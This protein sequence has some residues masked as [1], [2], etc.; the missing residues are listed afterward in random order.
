[1]R[2][3]ESGHRRAQAAQGELQQFGILFRARGFVCGDLGKTGNALGF[4]AVGLGKCGHL[5]FERAEQLEQFEPAIPLIASAPSILDS[6]FPM[7]SSIIALPFNF[8]IRSSG[9]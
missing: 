8:K 5:C 7:V 3:F 1:M 4:L 9:A 6:I 2:L